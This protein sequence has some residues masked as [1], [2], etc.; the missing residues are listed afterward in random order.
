M[1]DRDA[2]LGIDLG[3][4]DIKAAILDRAGQTLWQER[5]A[6][7]AKEAR[8]QVIQRLEDL[9][10]LALQHSPA[11]I[12]SAGFAIPGV[13]DMQTGR[14]E[15]LSNFTPE[16][17]GYLLRDDLE[18]RTGLHISVLNDV[19]AATVAEK[20][21]GAGRGF[22]DFI[23]IAIGT[24]I[25]G[26]LVLNGS[27]YQGS[28]G[29]AGEL[30]HQTVVPDGPLCGC[31]NRGCIEAFASGPALTRAARAAIEA[32]DMKLVELSGSSN[33]TPYAISQAAVQ[34]SET[35]RS[36]F[37]HAGTLVGRVLANLVC[38]LNP[39]AIVVGGGVSEAGDLLLQPIREEIARRTVVFS[40]ERGGVQVLHSP[41]GGRAGAIGAAAWALHHAPIAN[42]G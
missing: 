15:K 2:V 8:D 34:G 33:P 40:P 7:G 42:R 9:V 5:I 24:G 1:G 26:G 13:V 29:A 4:T 14:L 11:P 19:R 39:E 20:T 21:W 12:R 27:L 10:A 36:I 30:G 18:R 31:G 41:L 37:E 32:G 38:V 6:T 3:G 35:A 28:R 17:D 23:C 25:G 16:W 22:Q